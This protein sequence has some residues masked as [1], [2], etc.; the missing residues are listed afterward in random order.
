MILFQ[1]YKYW[2]KALQNSPSNQGIYV[3]AGIKKLKEEMLEKKY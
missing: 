3:H 2:Y 1:K